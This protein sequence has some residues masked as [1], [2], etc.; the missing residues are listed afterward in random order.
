MRVASSIVDGD[1]EPVWVNIE[2]EPLFHTLSSRFGGGGVLVYME[3]Q[4]INGVAGVVLIDLR[5]AGLE[6][7]VESRLSVPDRRRVEI[8][9]Q[10]WTSSADVFELE[11]AQGEV[12]VEEIYRGEGVSAL[13]IRF[14]LV[15]TDA[16][17]QWRRL[18]GSA[19]T[20]PTVTE[21]VIAEED[22]VYE[23]RARGEVYNPDGDIYVNCYGDAYVEEEEYDEDSYYYEDDD[24]GGCAGDTWDDD[25]EDPQESGGCVAERTVD[26]GEL[27]PDGGC[28]GTGDE[29]E[30]DKYEEDASWYGGDDYSDDQS[31][32]CD[33]DTDDGGG[34][35]SDGD[36]EGG[37]TGPECAGDTAEASVSPARR[38]RLRS[39]LASMGTN[40]H[41]RRLAGAAGFHR[42]GPDESRTAGR[43]F[44]YLP[45]LL[46]AVGIRA[47][48]RRIGPS[49]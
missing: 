20:S 10:E 30:P 2:A 24:G 7:L 36:D 45:F 25:V 33:E 16:A 48:R 38:T 37:D 13:G 4:P 12:T 3:Y 11:T 47:A 35:N 44:G 49:C 29:L 42:L 46:L 21:A 8:Y 28:E 43:V 31:S 14:D 27:D 40:R 19:T 1:G 23:R 39:Y 17:G 9:Y 5:H 32:G 26:D 34:D 41:R 22:V 18:Q 6:D 15:V